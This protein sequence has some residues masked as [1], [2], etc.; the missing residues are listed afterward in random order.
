MTQVR[1]LGENFYLLEDG[2]VR[3]FLILGAEEALLLDT[4]FPDGGVA[5]AVGRLTEL[6]VRVLLTH[7]D[8]DH[9]GG[10]AAFGSCCLHPGD[11]GMLPEEIRRAPIREGDIFSCGGYRLEAVEIPGHTPGSVAFLERER[12]LL[13]PGDSV[14]KGG[15]IY[16]FGPHRDLDAHIASLEK[17]LPLARLVDWVLPCHHDCPIAPDYIAGNLEDALA[18][19]AGK[20]PGEPTPGMPCSTYHGRWT[21]F[22]F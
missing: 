1:S 3:Q 4:G 11:W 7:G 8:R 19:R 15:P 6:P 13:L 18:L 9:T 20:L 12:R 5:E 10:L 22:Y 14:Q 2:R 17:L 21:D 16:M